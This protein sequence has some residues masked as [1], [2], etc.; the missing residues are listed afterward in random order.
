M[1]WSVYRSA[2]LRFTSSWRRAVLLS[3][4]C[5]LLWDPLPWGRVSYLGRG[6]DGCR[7][8]LLSRVRTHLAWCTAL[9][10]NS[11][12][13]R[14]VRGTTW[15]GSHWLPC[16]SLNVGGTQPGSGRLLG[17]CAS[18][19]GDSVEVQ[20]AGFS[21]HTYCERECGHEEVIYREYICIGCHVRVRS[22]I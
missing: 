6:R 12:S 13:S 3:P 18:V 10:L 2:H 8:L 16:V 15:G 9:M 5:F 19:G 17:R 1:G 21:T 11:C 14:S 22:N 4:A 20:V 7:D